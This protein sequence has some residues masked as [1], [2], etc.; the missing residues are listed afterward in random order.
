MIFGK[1]WDLIKK[2]LILLILCCIVVCILNYSYLNF[3]GFAR[4]CNSDVYADSLVAMMMWDQKT[5]FPDGWMFSNQFYVAATPNLAALFYGLT[6]SINL[7]MVLATELMTVLVFLSFLWLLRALTK[8]LLLQLT[9]CL[10]LLAANVAPY[11][12][13]S[14]NSML[15][16]TQASF[17]AC[18]LI[19][20]FV[21][22]GDYLRAYV[23]EETRP[24]AW[25]LS[26]VLSFAMGMQS[27]RQTVVMVLPILACEAFVTL[28]RALLRRKI[29][30]RNTLYRGI[31]YAVANMMG[32]AVIEWLDP[33][34]NPLFGQ[35]ELAGLESL[36]QRLQPLGT[37]LLEIT[38]LD[39]VRN[40]D[41]SKLMACIILGMV[42][43]VAIGAVLYLS[44]IHK[45][46][47]PL[48]LCWLLLAVGMIGV[49][50]STVV[51]TITI[52]GIYL[53]MWFPLAA[54]SVLLMMKKLPKLLQ[55]CLVLILCGSTLVGMRDGYGVYMQMLRAEKPT[56]AEQICQWAMEEGYRYVYGD[57]WGMATEIAV[58]SDGELK[59]GCW[60]TPESVF[61][62]E[63][64]NNSQNIYTEAEN[65]RAIY[66]FTS[67]DEASGLA[68]AAERGVSMEKAAEFGD[69]YVYTSPVPLMRKWGES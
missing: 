10:T 18:Y 2:I 24:A 16:F 61:Y 13:Y 11:G 29:W 4:Y 63:M 6:G 59:A 40:G 57:Y 9:A 67:E 64:A 42:L 50:L 34:K 12:P 37:A 60:H 62:V 48:E 31:S 55:L 46:E 15:F 28:R 66:V 54:C 22:F 21:V 8:D 27:L 7:G 23:S 47:T 51:L 45:E 36:A 30:N 41:C 26:L 14:V 58:H 32:V 25:T 5:L 19:T 43:L 69:C 20:M 44:R 68:S 33:P 65:A 49:L 3:T 39:Y 17:Y 56:E 52:R 35:V 53:F 38:S 1:K